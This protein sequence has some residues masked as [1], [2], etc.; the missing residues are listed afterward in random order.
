LIS[1]PQTAGFTG[2]FCCAS[3]L[4]SGWGFGKTGELCGWDAGLAGLLDASAIGTLLFAAAWF[5]GALK[6]CVGR[7]QN[8]K[9]TPP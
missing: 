6:W 2:I 7:I 9:L 4:L 8:R 5:T 3:T 1:R